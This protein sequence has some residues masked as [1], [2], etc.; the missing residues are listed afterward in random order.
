MNGS[1]RVLDQA[2]EDDLRSQV[3]GYEGQVLVTNMPSPVVG[4][5]VAPTAGWLL[6]TAHATCE[7]TLTAMRAWVAAG[8]LGPH[9]DTSIGRHTGARC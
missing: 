8:Q 9:R 4:D 2:L 6:R 3:H 7:A 1:R 5:G